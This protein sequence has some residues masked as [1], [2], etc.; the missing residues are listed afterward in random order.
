MPGEFTIQNKDGI[1]ATLKR[2]EISHADKTLGVFIAMDGN[3]EA[4][5]EHL[6]KLSE[7]FGHQLRTAKCEKNASMYTLQYS[8]MKTFEYPMVATQLDEGTWTAI[9]RPTLQSALQ[10]AGMSMNFPRD[11]LFGP[12][13]FQGYQLQHP[14]YTQEISHITTLLQESVR[15]SQTGKLLRLTAECLRL[16]LGIPLQLGST[17]Y[18]PFAPYVTDCWYKT[19]WKFA[20]EHPIQIHEDYPN[21]SILRKGDQFLMQAFVDH[22]FRGQELEWLN[23][24][25]MAIKAISLADIVTADGTAITHQAYLLKHSNGLRDDLDWPRAPPGG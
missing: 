18:K 8:L 19:L 24:M 11:V 7:K 20:S 25:R 5:I 2:H 10:K 14:Y 1:Q 12:A 3:E 4:E 22:G 21:V 23:I 15:N 9:L 17:P 6:K 16:E 13:L